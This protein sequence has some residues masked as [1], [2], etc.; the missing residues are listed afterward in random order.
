MGDTAIGLS[1]LIPCL[2][3]SPCVPACPSSWWSLLSFLSCPLLH[4]CLSQHCCSFLRN[5]A[6][7]AAGHT[8]ALL[9]TD[10]P[11]PHPSALEAPPTECTCSTKHAHL[12][13]WPGPGELRAWKLP[14]PLDWSHLL[15]TSKMQGS[16]S[17]GVAKYL[18][19]KCRDF[20]LALF[21]TSHRPPHLHLRHA[22]GALPVGPRRCGLEGLDIQEA[23]P[24]G[25]LS[26]KADSPWRHSCPPQALRMA[27]PLS[28][29]IL[30]GPGLRRC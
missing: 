21:L 7:S 19:G 6:S 17:S 28:A 18:R 23:S 27:L 11:P 9:G 22:K 26:V 13:P 16:L 29:L 4:C 12:V 15:P 24:R 3:Q 8:Q 5:V 25:M 20:P 30:V 1:C 2:G 14:S 10:T